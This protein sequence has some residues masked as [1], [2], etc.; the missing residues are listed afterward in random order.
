M[1]GTSLAQ[2][3]AVLASVFLLYGWAITRGMPEASARAM[4]FAAI[5]IGNIGLVFANRS[6]TMSG[7]PADTANPTLWWLVGGA[8][9][10]LALSLYVAPLREAFRFAPLSPVELALSVLAGAAGFAL[11]AASNRLARQVPNAACE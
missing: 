8:L 10:G 5:V 3:M 11:V 9:G 7:E 2:G 1:I 6:R 4:T